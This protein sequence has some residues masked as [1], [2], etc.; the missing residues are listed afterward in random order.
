MKTGG[1]NKAGDRNVSV[2]A[3]PAAS[4]LFGG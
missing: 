4:R 1:S 2:Q 3:R